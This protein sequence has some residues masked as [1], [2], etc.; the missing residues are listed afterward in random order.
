MKVTAWGNYP[1]IESEITHLRSI[2]Q[3][4]KELKNKESLIPMGMARSYGDSALNENIVLTKKFNRFLSFDEDKGILTCESGVTLED[5]LDVFVPRGWFLSVTPGTKFITVGGAIASDVHGKNHHVEGTFCNHVLSLDLMQPS[6]EIVTCSPSKNSKLFRATCGGNGLT[7]IIISATFKMKRIETAYIK[8]K[9]LKAKNLYEL[10]EFLE[11]NEHYTYTVAWVDCQARNK[12]MGRGY[13]MMGEHAVQN[14][15][16]KK[17]LKGNLLKL[18]EKNKLNIPVFL[19]NLVLN[20]LIIKIF[21]QL[22]YSTAPRENVSIIDYDSFFYP[23]DAITNWN[24]IYGK[25]GFTQYQFVIPKEVGIQGLSKIFK[26]ISDEGMGSFLAVLKIAGAY[27]QNLLSFP[28]EG[29]T[30]ALDFPITP[31]LFTFLNEL[32][33]M[34]MDYG[35]RLYLTKDVR[36]SPEMFQKGYPKW[37]E[38]MT[39]R[40]QIGADKKFHSLQ[41]KRL[42]I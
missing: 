32:D 35:G 8:Q 22:I 9:I 6:G 17:M 11:K 20:K 25:K 19:P 14:D 1:Q 5:I 29:Y 42:E 13:L 31:G 3:I 38:F 41:S 10:V 4:Q 28:T 34:I 30:L 15:L 7:G 39:I 12:K 24:R 27:N 37:K 2:Q 40:K 21:N 33:R 18:K 23:L 16:P 36:M 26:K